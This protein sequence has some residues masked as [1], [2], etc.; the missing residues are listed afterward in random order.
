MVNIPNDH[1]IVRVLKKYGIKRRTAEE[2]ADLRYNVNID[3][4]KMIELYKSG[5]PSTKIAKI[6]N[7]T[8]STI[9]L[10]LRRRGIQTR[11]ATECQIGRKREPYSEEHK[12]ALSKALMG[13]SVSKETRLKISKAHIGEGNPQYG[14]SPSLETRMKLSK[15]HKGEKSYL[16]KGGITLLTKQIRGCF[17]Y[18]QWRSDIFTRDDFTCQE[19]GK[20]GCYFHAHHI[21]SFTSI[22]QYYEITTIEEAL[23]CSELWNINNGITLCKK[24]HRKIHKE[25]INNGSD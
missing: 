4:N 8:S 14:K 6:F 13:H 9:L 11:N 25:M 19:C 7:T 5:K 12:K 18:R 20:R 2:I 23:E 15:V 1:I 10:K 22:L 24:C 21:K 3:I 17:E 16:W